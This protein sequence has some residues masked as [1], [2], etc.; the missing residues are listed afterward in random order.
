MDGWM[1]RTWLTFKL[2]IVV[3]EA[4]VIVLFCIFLLFRDIRR[5]PDGY[6]FGFI[7]LLQMLVE[8]ELVVETLAAQLADVPEDNHGPVTAATLPFPR[9]LALLAPLATL[10]L[11][12]K[13]HRNQG[14]Q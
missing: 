8:H 13:P 14:E 3:H 2:L 11:V 10:V 5:I 9:L 6:V 12:V 1:M 4:I 7:V